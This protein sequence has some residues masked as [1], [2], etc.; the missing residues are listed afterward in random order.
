MLQQADAC[1]YLRVLRKMDKISPYTLPPG[2][3]YLSSYASPL[4]SQ[5]LGFSRCLHSLRTVSL[6]IRVWN[7]SHSPLF[8]LTHK[9]ILPYTN[10]FMDFSNN[11]KYL[12]VAG[13]GHGK[14]WTIFFHRTG[15]TCY[16]FSIPLTVYFYSPLPLEKKSKF[17]ISAQV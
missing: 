1:L 9:H 13:M 4:N 16:P 3:D 10:H 17:V 6:S 7:S 8:S 2:S 11:T 14:W 12:G 15:S 5:R